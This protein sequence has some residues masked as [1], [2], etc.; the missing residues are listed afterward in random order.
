MGIT[1]KQLPLEIDLSFTNL[2]TNE[3]INHKNGLHYYRFTL[4]LKNI[5]H[6]EYQLISWQLNIINDQSKLFPF[7][8]NFG[9]LLFPLQSIFQYQDTCF[10]NSSWSTADFIIKIKDKKR[11]IQTISLKRKYISNI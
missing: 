8:G 2:E 7:R 9:K 3:I 11:N 1:P 4:N 5:Y 6:E 10:S